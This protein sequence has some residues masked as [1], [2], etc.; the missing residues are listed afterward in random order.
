MLLT[1]QANADTRD[2]DQLSAREIL[3][4]MNRE[5]AKVAEAVSRQLDAIARVVE[6]VTTRIQAGGRLFYVGCGTSGRLG[7]L[8]A[9]A[10]PPAFGIHPAL[11]QG[12]LAGGWR[13]ALT[14]A[15]GVEDD[16]PQ[17][18]RDLVRAGLSA[19][20]SVVGITASGSTPYTLGAVQEASQ[21]GAFTASVSCNEGAEISRLVDEPIEVLCGPEVVTG[22]TRLKAGTAQKM[23]L[24]MISTATMV[25]LGNVHSNLMVNLNLS[26]SKL[27]ARA[28]RIVADAAGATPREAE[29]AL[30]E[31]GDVRSAIVMLALAC[32]ADEAR[33]LVSQSARLNEILRE[34]RSH[35]GVVPPA[36]PQQ[37]K[38]E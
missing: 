8:D 19:R 9:I 4:L 36:A 29:D 15:D 2:L 26:N 16:R 11:V 13:A 35:P 23:V 32:T 30:K 38:S 18:A 6:T 1:E 34:Q 27:V 33:G 12:V 10:C 37:G 28:I 3:Q 21:M 25:R 31:T 24:N 22:C 7:L 5:D 14:A 20:D 17:G